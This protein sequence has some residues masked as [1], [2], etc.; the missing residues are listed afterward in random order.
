MNILWMVIVGACIG[1]VASMFVQ[2]SRTTGLFEAIVLGMV[3]YG[4]SG[5]VAAYFGAGVFVQWL[6]G[7]G[8]TAVIITGYIGVANALRAR[9]LT[10]AQ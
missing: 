7:I 1:L 10:V 8:V 6:C 5:W 9:K 2:G 4:L 3:C